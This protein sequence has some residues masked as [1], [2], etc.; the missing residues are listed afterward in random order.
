M[1]KINTSVSNLED[2]KVNLEV[3]VSAEE[4]KSKV[5]KTLKKMAREVNIPGF[6]KGKIPRPVLFSKIG[7]ESILAQVLSDSLPEWYDRAVAQSGIKVIDQPE[8]DIDALEEEDK[9]FSFKATVSVPPKPDLGEYVG[10]ELEKDEVEID[11]SEVDDQIERLRMSLANLEKVD[12]KKAEKGDFVLIDFTGYIDNEPLEGGAGKD[13]SLELGSNSFIP[14]FEEGIEGMEIGQSKKLTLEFPEDYRP[15]HLAGKE[16]I[17]DVEL[18]E[19]KERVLPELNDGF[20][21]EASEYDTLAE[22]KEDITNKIRKTKED[23]NERVF[24]QKAVDKAT[25]EAEVDIPPVMIE[26]RLAE[27]K[28]E[29]G[30]TLKTQGA[31]I[32]MYLAHVGMDEKSLDERLSVE[33]ESYVRQELVVDAIAEAEDIEVS[34]E[35]I[36]QEIRETAERMGYDPE[37]LLKGAEEAGHKDVIRRDLKRRRAIDIITDKAKVIPVKAEDAEVEAEEEKEESDKE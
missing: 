4:V 31:S 8:L 30:S 26:S 9:P 18:K 17:F 36:E 29:L 2:N 14:G 22:L 20:A 28:Q 23:N 24:R 25:A 19:I 12:R 32:E 15:E 13:H 16:V 3:E 21:E 10:M 37:E 1:T 5:D 7:K 35:D 33:A 11:D 27:M 6:R 34:K